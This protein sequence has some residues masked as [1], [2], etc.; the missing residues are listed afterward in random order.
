MNFGSSDRKKKSDAAAAQGRGGN[1]KASA[2]PQSVLF[3]DIVPNTS[4]FGLQ[5]LIASDFLDE[6]LYMHPILEDRLV[7][8]AS[9]LRALL[10]ATRGVQPHVTIKQF[11]SSQL[12]SFT[13]GLSALYSPSSSLEKCAISS[14]VLLLNPIFTQQITPDFL[15]RAITS[16]LMTHRSTVVVGKNIKY[17]NQMISILS[18]FLKPKEYKRARFLLNPKARYVPDLLLQGLVEEPS[19]RKLIQSMLPSTIV[20]I[21]AQTVQQTLLMFHYQKFRN[22]WME[23]E[24]CA[25]LNNPVAKNP[26]DN[27]SSSEKKTGTLNEPAPS[28]FVLVQNLTLLPPHLH[29]GYIREWCRAGT[30]KAFTL[31]RYVEE[32]IRRPSLISAREHA[33]HPPASSTSSSSSSPSSSTTAPSASTLSSASLSSISS[34]LTSP[35]ELSL[36]SSSPSSSASTSPT[37]SL[38]ASQMADLKKQVSSDQQPSIFEPDQLVSQIQQ[39]HEPC[40]DSQAPLTVLDIESILKIRAHLQLESHTDFA[41]LLAEA[42]SY[43]PIISQHLSQWDLEQKLFSLIDDLLG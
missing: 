39:T 15:A 32:Y 8:V 10:N 6:Y 36:S 38:S 35:P 37:S 33:D 21:D 43:S 11:S 29:Y 5:V 30:I 17:V 7:R 24:L 31:I 16:H 41:I 27:L 19:E 2:R 3:D 28:V 18:A 34:P 1:R 14:R 23:K 13:T 12:Y 9:R 26:S 25:F 4:R 42:E 22:K 40:V 20:N